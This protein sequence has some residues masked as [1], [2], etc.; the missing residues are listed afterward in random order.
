MGEWAPGESCPPQLPSAPSVSVLTHTVGG[1]SKAAHQRPP[2]KTLYLKPRGSAVFPL[3]LAHSQSP[4]PPPAGLGR[5]QRSPIPYP[6]G[7]LPFWNTSRLLFSSCLRHHF[8]LSLFPLTI[9]EFP[10]T[11]GF[12]DS[13]LQT[14]TES[15]PSASPA[16]LSQ[17]S[18]LLLAAAHV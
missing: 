15:L 14:E 8:L 3:G 1:P 16:P 18:H 10:V 17:T 7:N 2:W 6:R 13:L 9:S 11:H 12:V 5:R 4:P